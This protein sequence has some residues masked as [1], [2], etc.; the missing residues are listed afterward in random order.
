MK[1]VGGA[2]TYYP[3]HNAYGAACKDLTPTM[4]R[5]IEKADEQNKP[6]LDKMLQL[7]TSWD[8]RSVIDVVKDAQFQAGHTIFQEWLPRAIAMTFNDEFAEIEEFKLVR[9]G[10]FN[11]FLRCIDGPTSPLPVSRNYFDDINTEK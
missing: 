4:S 5:A 3:Q 11:L 8:G 7:L 2:G 10:L 9:S 1:Y 6:L